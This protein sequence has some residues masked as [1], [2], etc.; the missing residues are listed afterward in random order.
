MNWSFKTFALHVTD[1]SAVLHTCRCLLVYLFAG[2]FSSKFDNLFSQFTKFLLL[3]CTNIFFSYFDD[4]MRFYFTLVKSKLEHTSSVYNSV[5]SY[6]KSTSSKDIKS[7]FHYAYCLYTSVLRD[8]KLHSFRDKMC[9]LD[10]LFITSDYFAVISLLPLWK[11]SIFEF[12]LGISD[13]VF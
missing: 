2:L 4:L 3:F 13:N 12:M 5:S 8:I 7:L 1:I 11:I 6:L 10:A 9:L